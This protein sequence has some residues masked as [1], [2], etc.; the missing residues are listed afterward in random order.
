MKLMELLEQGKKATRELFDYDYIYTDDV[1]GT[2][3][4]TNNE[5]VE[6]YNIGLSDLTRNDWYEYKEYKTN[7]EFKEGDKY[8]SENER[9][10]IYALKYEKLVTEDEAIE[11]FNAFPNKEL[12]EFIQKKQLLER[13]LMVFSYL[14]G[15]SEIDWSDATCKY[16]IETINN[17]G[18]I[19]SKKEYATWHQ[20]LDNVFFN[21]EEICEKAMELYENE[22][23]EVMEMKIKLGF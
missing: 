13:E 12:A 15:C 22:I 3:A 21:N 17:K 7:F 20:S 4:F 18:G 6:M 14:N 5:A 10:Y 9:G 19:K 8:Y 23:K 16:Y 11:N 1:N 2:F